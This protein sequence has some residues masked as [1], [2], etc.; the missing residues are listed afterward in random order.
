[1]ELLHIGVPTTEVKENETY[2]KD[3]KVYVTS[4]DDHDFKY[5]YLRFD[6]DSWMPEEIQ[7]QVHVAIQVDS[8]AEYL[9]KVDR[10]L[11]EPLMASDTMQICFAMKDGVVLELVEMK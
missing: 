10:I 9:K 11:V 6:E 3:M 7:K 8:I 4:P 5:E 1:M 2:M